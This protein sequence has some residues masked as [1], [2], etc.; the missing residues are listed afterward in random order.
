MLRSVRPLLCAPVFVCLL[1]GA[2]SSAASARILPFDP[3]RAAQISER[4]GELHRRA[5]AK[6]A[7]TNQDDFDVVRYEIDLR[8]DFDTQTVEGAVVVEFAPLVADLQRLD[9]DFYDDWSVTRVRPASGGRPLS[10]THQDSVLSIQLRTDGPGGPSGRAIRIEY[11]GTP[12]PA[13]F[14]GMQFLEH[15]GTP[16]LATLSQPFFARSWWPCKDVPD[17]KATVTLSCTVPP[18][19]YVAGNG[20]LESTTTDPSTGDVTYTWVEN[21]P[22]STSLVGFSATNYVG[23]EETYVSKSGRAM[24]V[25]F[26]V[27]PEDL[28]AARVDFERT[29]DMLDLFSGLFGEYPFVEEK[30]GMAEIVFEG[31]IEHQTMTGYGDFL[32]TGDKQFERLVAHE[33]SHNWWGNSITVRDW[34]E[35]W[36]QEGFATY[37]EALW[38]EAQEGVDAYRSFMRSRSGA[39]TGFFGPIV[40]PNRLFN[41]TVYWKGAWVLHMLR[42]ILGDEGFFASLRAHAQNPDLKYGNQTTADLVE[43]ISRTTGVDTQTF[44]DQWLY[45]VGRPEYTVVWSH[46]PVDGGER[47]DVEI[48][49]TQGNGVVYAMPLDLHVPTASG[50]VVER[51]VWNDQSVQE[52]SFVVP[53]EPTD[54]V[55]DPDDWVLDEQI[56]TERVGTSVAAPA[57][58]A[59]SRLLPPEPN[60]FN[61]RTRLRY[62]L[63]R[64]GRVDLT[65]HDARGRRVATLVAGE[66]RSAGTHTVVWAGDD[67]AG[68]PVSTGVYFARMQ[69]DGRIRGESVRLVLVR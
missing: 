28:D 17:D 63:A 20:V 38:I 8:P 47:V 59:S 64:S 56:V 60:P 40:P 39:E 37:C 68:R 61:P 55:V 15:D 21:Y 57:V 16:I 54:L 52:Y 53:G 30:Y 49:Q 43:T 51:T 6:S 46:G 69:V 14:L 3:D 23:W 45:N 48:R 36:L 10:Y 42:R 24:D 7:T 34:N 4:W 27:F 22:I 11:N 66:L 1:L 29:V 26:R 33:L 12:Q 19:F 13:G 32:I 25:I 5:A 62:D 35:L 2:L 41:T 31:A 67:D 44:F 18:E 65:V 9:L 58:P 50:S